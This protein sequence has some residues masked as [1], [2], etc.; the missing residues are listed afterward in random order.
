[1]RGRCCLRRAAWI[2]KVWSERKWE[3]DDS[4]SRRRSANS[5]RSGFVPNAALAP[6]STVSL[7][8]SCVIENEENCDQSEED[9]A[10]QARE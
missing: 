8:G 10:A 6:T 3:I 5:F 2:S 4:A 9:R 7:L 1:M